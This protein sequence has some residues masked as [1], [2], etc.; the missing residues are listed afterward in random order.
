MDTN[1]PQSPNFSSSSMNPWRF[2]LFSGILILPAFCQ[3]QDVRAYLTRRWLE[4]GEELRM[5]VAC[6]G[7]A[8]TSTPEFPELPDFDMGNRYVTVQTQGASRITI[9][10]QTYIP[11][12]T[13]TFVVPAIVIPF[14][15]KIIR[16]SPGIVTVR[17]AS[18]QSYVGYSPAKLDARLV[19]ELDSETVQLGQIQRGILYLEVPWEQR[20]HLTWDLGALAEMADSI[21][22]SEPGTWILLD[23]LRSNGLNEGIREDGKIRFPCYEAWWGCHDQTIQKVTGTRLRIQRLW[24][25][26][27]RY[28]SAR[29]PAPRWKDEFIEV[30]ET[31]WAVTSPVNG[32]QPEIAPSGPLT[33][34]AAWQKSNLITGEPLPI[35][36]TIIGNVFLNLVPPPQFDIPEG[37]VLRG[38]QIRTSYEISDG[39]LLG[40]KTL[41]Y[42]LYPAIEGSY[43]LPKVKLFWLSADDS[44]IDSVAIPL[45]IVTV[46]GDAIP[47]LLEQQKLES[48]YDKKAALSNSNQLGSFA[49]LLPLAY[50]ILLGACLMLGFSLKA[51]HQHLQQK[52]RQQLRSKRYKGH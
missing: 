46:T 38:P 7:S 22:R 39:T 40:T 49:W 47:Q 27:S 52:R 29:S 36:T 2:I 35:T 33:M 50:S 25:P 23:S 41:D 42:L 32:L 4:E 31:A 12:T 26:V 28:R 15:D 37:M 48:F 24:T 43:V 20:N 8:P 34:T 3:S 14:R 1:Y 45:P 17:Q 44:Q 30:A 18:T 16:K 5:I 9:Y 6:R 51:H 11:R 21:R 10:D 13:G 19:W